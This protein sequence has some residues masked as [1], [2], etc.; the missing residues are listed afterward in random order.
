M[1]QWPPDHFATLIDWLT[2]TRD[3]QVVLVGSEEESDLAAQILA[4]I[5]NAKKVVSVVGLTTVKDMAG[6]IAG[7]DLFIGN[8]SGPHHLAASM[9]VPTIGI[10]SGVV[11]SR[12]W[13]PNGPSA[14]AVSRRMVCSPCY[15]AKPEDCP[16]ALACLTELSPDSVI[17]LAQTML[18]GRPDRSSRPMPAKG[19]GK[20][21]RRVASQ[22]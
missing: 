10:H 4:M 1:R 5:G 14:V 18:A 6:L 2:G 15:I 20:G 22:N 16:R 21:R 11:D 7:C 13:G 17:A 3:C 12:E 9:N 19:A 8:N